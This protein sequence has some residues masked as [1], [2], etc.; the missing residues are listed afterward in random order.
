MVSFL[1]KEKRQS[2]SAS[3]NEWNEST[4]KNL[5]KKIRKCQ[6]PIFM[7]KHTKRAASLVGPLLCALGA[8]FQHSGRRS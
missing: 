7:Y 8:M 6:Q 2:S 4:L 3:V 1:L 5:L